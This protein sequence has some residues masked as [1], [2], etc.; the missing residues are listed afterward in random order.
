MQLRGHN[1]S[2]MRGRKPPPSRPYVSPTASS[3][4]EPLMT[5]NRMAF[6]GSE[7]P[8]LAVLILPTVDT[9]MRRFVD[10]SKANGASYSSDACSRLVPSPVIVVHHE[11]G[12]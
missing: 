10:A 2:I 4:L 5:A 12:L 6:L 3:Q 9:V 11:F 7:A 8:L 1:R